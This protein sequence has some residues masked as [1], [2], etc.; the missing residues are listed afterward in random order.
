MEER[1]SGTWKEEKFTL[2]KNFHC[3]E[4]CACSLIHQKLFLM[5]FYII[6]K[7]PLKI[8]LK[9]PFTVISRSQVLEVLSLR[10]N[11]IKSVCSC[12][13][14]YCS[15]EKSSASE[16]KESKRRRREKFSSTIPFKFNSLIKQSS[17]ESR[18]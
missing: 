1:N 16:N 13:E 9:V 15:G 12:S 5:L 8:E 14:F 18:V 2:R 7:V 6:F 11:V 17:R 10:S 4:L 3:A